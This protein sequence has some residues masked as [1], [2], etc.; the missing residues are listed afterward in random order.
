[1]RRSWIF[2]LILPTL[3]LQLWY[4]IPAREQAADLQQQATATRSPGLVGTA[5]VYTETPIIP[6]VPLVTSTPLADGAVYHEV[7]YGQTLWDIALAYEL[8]LEE[9]RLL[10]NMAPDSTDIY[11]GQKLLIRLP[12]TP[13]VTPTSAE[14]AAAQAT[15]EAQATQTPQPTPTLTPTP[16]PTM[17]LAAL[18]TT[19]TA[20]PAVQAPSAFNFDNYRVPIAYGLLG[21]AGIGLVLWLVSFMVESKHSK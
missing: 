5:P 18:V 8:T 11:A 17:A 10:N 1:M 20:T 19:Q 15:G 21:L 13:Y 9:V 14:T 12:G 3:L 6:I 7:G 2:I 4:A 16:H